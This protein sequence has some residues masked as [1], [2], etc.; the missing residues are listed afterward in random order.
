MVLY[1]T[2]SLISCFKKCHYTVNVFPYHIFFYDSA[3]NDS[4]MYR[5]LCDHS[6]IVGHLCGFQYFASTKTATMNIL[7]CIPDDFLRINSS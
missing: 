5:N 7:V 1:D 2:H 3:F 4:K 6:S